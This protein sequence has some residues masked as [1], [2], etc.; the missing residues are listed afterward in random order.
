MSSRKP[1]GKWAGANYDPARNIEIDL[2][3][4]HKSHRHALQRWERLNN[5]MLEMI[6]QFRQDLLYDY[7][8]ELVHFRKTLRWRVKNQSHWS[9]ELQPDEW[10]ALSLGLRHNHAPD[11]FMS[12]YQWLNINKVQVGG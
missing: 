9:I 4:G 10:Q 11:G 8:S 6:Y 1:Q 3:G 12:M 2:R 7:A 5:M